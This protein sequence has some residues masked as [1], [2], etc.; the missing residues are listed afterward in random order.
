MHKNRLSHCYEIA[1]TSWCVDEAVV[2]KKDRLP[3]SCLD[4]SPKKYKNR[5]ENGEKI[6]TKKKRKK[7]RVG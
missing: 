3:V 1:V 7:C 5:L 4:P 6:I 2:F